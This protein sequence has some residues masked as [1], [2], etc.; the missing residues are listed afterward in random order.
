VI[1]TLGID[2]FDKDKF[3][4]PHNSEK[5]QFLNKP[6]GGLWGSTFTPNYNYVSD[7]AMFVFENDFATS[8]YRSGIVYKLNSNARVLNIDT[9]YDFVKLLKNFGC[10]SLPEYTLI[11]SQN[12]R[13]IDW[14][15]IVKFYDAVHFSREAVMSCRFIM[16][17]EQLD[18]GEVFTVSN[19]YSYDCESWV[20][21]NPDVIDMKSICK[22]EIGNKGQ[23]V[24]A[25]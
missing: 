18:N 23:L 13:F 1:L 24:N 22:I 10:V 8:I 21:C 20:V 7:W 12:K 4:I 5:S 3:E 19:L 15:K 25:N 17:E 11:Y 9:H 6:V 16:N 2:N 14:D